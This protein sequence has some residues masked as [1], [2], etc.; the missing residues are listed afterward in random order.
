MA[1]LNSHQRLLVL[2]AMAKLA[3]ECPHLADEL[4]AIADKF[5]GLRGWEHVEAYIQQQKE[6]GENGERLVRQ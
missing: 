3:V 6:N 2:M 1:I 4:R 5:G